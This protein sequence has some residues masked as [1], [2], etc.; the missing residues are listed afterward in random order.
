MCLV[1]QV[2]KE[3]VIVRKEVDDVL[4]G[5]DTWHAAQRSENSEWL[6]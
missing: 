4:G 6:V 2:N 3:V 1:W 5:E